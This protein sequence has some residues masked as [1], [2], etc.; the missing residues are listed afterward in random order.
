MH[1]PNYAAA[2][3]G[4][5]SFYRLHHPVR[6]LHLTG[7][8][9]VLN[10]ARRMGDSALGFVGRPLTRSDLEPVIT[11]HGYGNPEAPLWFLGLEEARA[12]RREVRDTTGDLLGTYYAIT[13]GS[14]RHPLGHVAPLLRRPIETDPT[15]TYLE[16]G[17]RSFGKGTFHKLP[18]L[19][20]ELGSKRVF[21]IEPNDLLFNIV[22]AWEGAVA[23]A[24]PGDRGRVGSHRFL[25]CVPKP[26]VATPSFLCFH[27]LTPEG[28]EQLGTAS[29]G[30]AG[31]NRTL[32][33]EALA[34]IPVPTPSID[35]PEVV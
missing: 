7:A 22:F 31:R 30:A 17:I 27:F 34:K 28:L 14:P 8:R 12:L 21:R 16:I 6:A 11:H 10:I 15:A 29:P 13:Q 3:A 2:L 1:F 25:T 23:V 5:S 32:G 35:G 4:L 19:G 18:V 26:D 9:V 24:R 33:Q 20:A